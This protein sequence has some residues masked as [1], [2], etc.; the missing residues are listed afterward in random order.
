MR[1]VMICFSLLSLLLPEGAFSAHAAEKTYTNSIGMEFVL[2]PAGSFTMGADRNFEDAAADETPQH[3][4]NVSK[5]FYLGGYEVTQAQWEAVMGNNPSEFKGR[6]N[7]AEQVSWGDAQAFIRRLNAWVCL[8]VVRWVTGFLRCAAV[9]RTAPPVCCF[10]W[11]TGKCGF[12]ADLS[13]RRKKRPRRPYNWQSG[14]CASF[15]EVR[16][17]RQN[18]SESGPCRWLL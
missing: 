13:R 3:R 2:I 5:P 11:R 16:Y 8:Y 1:S 9:W 15:W 14:G 4:V 6:S 10:A 7:P 12:C 18:T 17:E